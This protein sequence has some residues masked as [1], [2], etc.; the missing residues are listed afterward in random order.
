MSRESWERVLK[1]NGWNTVELR[2]NRYNQ[3][4]HLVTSA[5]GAE[6]YYNVEDNPCRT[7]GLELARELDRRTIEAWV[8]HPYIDVIDNSTD[9]DTKMRRMISVRSLHILCHILFFTFD[10][11]LDCLSSNWNRTW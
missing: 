3:V 4:I 11:F 8:G 10:V 1:T 7:E 9:F 6:E 5:D 2:D